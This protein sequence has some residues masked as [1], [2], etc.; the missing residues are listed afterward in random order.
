M[1]LAVLVGTGL[2]VRGGVAGRPLVPGEDGIVRGLVRGRTPL[3]TDLSTGAS[4]LG[5]TGSVL[6]LLL[7]VTGAF[8][9][10]YRRWREAG[11][12]VLA[13]A[14]QVVLFLLTTLLVSRTRP[15]VVQLDVAPLTSSFPSGHT[16]ATTALFVGTA[17][18]LAW[19]GRDRW[20]RR[21][22]LVLLLRAL[23]P[24]LARVLDGTARGA[25][26]VSPPGR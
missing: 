18:V 16:G 24:R 17:V 19:R 10:R 14:S 26:A 7:A 6:V 23:P 22:L 11:F 21:P 12:L 20:R 4:L 3:A 15:D 9:L 5:S 13:V 8:R 25:P 2:L 1:L